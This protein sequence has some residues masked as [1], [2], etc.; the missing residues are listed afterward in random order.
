LQ[1]QPP[2]RVLFYFASHIPDFKVDS[3]LC[4]STEVAGKGSSLYIAQK[5]LEFE[6][7]QW[8]KK[9]MARPIAFCLGNGYR[10]I[11]PIST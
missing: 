11:R 10:R 5:W 2:G 9:R 3:I 4:V 1:R 8:R 7:H 6:A